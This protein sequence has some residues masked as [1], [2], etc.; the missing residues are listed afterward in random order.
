VE[1]QYGV[2]VDDF[3]VEFYEK[4]DDK[5]FIAKAF[6]ESAI[7]SVHAYSDDNSYRSIYVNCTRLTKAVDKVGEFLSA[8]LTASP[9]IDDRNPVGFT[10]LG[11]DGIGG[12]RIKKEDIAAF[13]VSHR[14]AL[15]T[16]QLT[17]QQS[18]RVFSLRDVEKPTQ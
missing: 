9:E 3:L 4:D 6:H 2:G 13:F 14:T 7:E 1:D 8:S 10:T 18:D 15:V 11:D 17:R 12:I 16:L 5:G